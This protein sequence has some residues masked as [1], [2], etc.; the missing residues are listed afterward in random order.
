MGR[1]PLCHGNNPPGTLPQ[2]S[3]EIQS[4]ATTPSILVVVYPCS[5]SLLIRTSLLG[6][7]VR[8]DVKRVPD[9]SPLC[10]IS[11]GW[12]GTSPIGEV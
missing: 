7:A 1:L 4:F 6:Q 8:A 11:I 5:K 9:A 10:I 2:E 3:A 12:K